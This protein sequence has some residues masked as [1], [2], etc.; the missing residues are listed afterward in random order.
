MTLGLTASSGYGDMFCALAAIANKMLGKR[1]FFHRIAP[2]CVSVLL[3]P[4]KRSE[5]GCI[6]GAHPAAIRH[7]FL[8]G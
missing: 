7:G 3:L 8:T 1:G 6:V 5:A 4:P 2:I